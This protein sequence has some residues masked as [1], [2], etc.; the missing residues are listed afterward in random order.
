[1]ALSPSTSSMLA[2]ADGCAHTRK[3]GCNRGRRSRLQAMLLRNQSTCISASGLIRK[4]Q[5]HFGHSW[6]IGSVE[7]SPV[8]QPRV[9]HLST[10]F[11]WID[12]CCYV[13]SSLVNN[14]QGE[15][16]L[17]RVRVIEIRARFIEHERQPFGSACPWVGHHQL[18]PLVE[19]FSHL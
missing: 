11:G 1:M 14:V 15:H 8:A 18:N 6:V 7:S 3:S 16:G 5:W 4:N 13:D 19:G 9:L 2:R 12:R 10:L 17:P